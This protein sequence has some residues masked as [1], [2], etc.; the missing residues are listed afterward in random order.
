MTPEQL[1]NWLGG[2]GEEELAEFAR[3]HATLLALLDETW[4]RFVRN[5]ADK[6]GGKSTVPAPACLEDLRHESA[7]A[8]EMAGFLACFGTDGGRNDRPFGDHPEIREHNWQLMESGTILSDVRT[9]DTAG[10]EPAPFTFASD[11]ED[12]RA[13]ADDAVASDG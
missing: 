2:A 11:G 3:E 1:K 13:D 12:V 9:D 8:A 4:Q 6:S 5:R 7:D 10:T